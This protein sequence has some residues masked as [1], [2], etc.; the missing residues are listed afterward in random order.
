MVMIQDRVYTMLQT[1]QRHGVS[2]TVYG[3]VHF[4]EPLKSFDKSRAIP[5]C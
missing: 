5:E 4:K 3:T 2:S 1:V